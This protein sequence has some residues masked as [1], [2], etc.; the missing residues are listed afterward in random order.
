VL[1]R[2]KRKVS[3]ADPAAAMMAVSVRAGVLS[4]ITGLASK[5]FRAKA[6]LEGRKN[7]VPS[8]QE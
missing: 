8:P 5:Q 3:K 4:V 6:E 1:P 7:S 2:S